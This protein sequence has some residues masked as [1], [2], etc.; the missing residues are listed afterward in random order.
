MSISRKLG[1]LGGVTLANTFC[2]RGLF[3]EYDKDHND[4]LSL[5]EVSAM[6]EGLSKKVTAL[7][8]TA[9]VASQQ[10]KYLGKMFS[11]LAKSRKA[12][13]E[14]DMPDLDDEAY[15]KAFEYQHLGSLAYIGNSC[16]VS[17][18]HIPP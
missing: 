17:S 12:L 18:H 14:N 11:K 6:F 8:A 5:N 16:V 10:G 15:Y 13:Q 9:Q 2:R 7:P 4:R 1:R 3:D